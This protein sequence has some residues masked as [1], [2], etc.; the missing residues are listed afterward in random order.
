MWTEERNSWI[1]RA[2]WK[3]FAFFSSRNIVFLHRY[4]FYWRQV[5]YHNERKDILYKTAYKSSWGKF[6]WNFAPSPLKK[7]I[8]FDT[9]TKLV[10]T[11]TGDFSKIL[12]NSQKSENRRKTI[13]FRWIKSIVS[14]W[15][16]RFVDRC[17]KSR[18]TLHIKDQSR[19]WRGR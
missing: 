8:K 17:S 12:E 15:S 19:I 7:T 2:H 18:Q 5:I 6:C 1:L 3:V 4:C 14:V 13:G 11:P 10:L 9:K 16:H